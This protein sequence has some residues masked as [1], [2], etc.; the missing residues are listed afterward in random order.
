MVTEVGMPHVAGSLEAVGVIVQLRRITPVNPSE[1]V[2]VIVDV[3]PAV[4][5]RATLTA[6]PVIEKL[7]VGGTIVY[8]ALDTPL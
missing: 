4:A 6:V 8:V 7:G 5:P 1:G 2:K 3:F